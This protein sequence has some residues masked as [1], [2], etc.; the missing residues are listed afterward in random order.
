[1]RK[2]LGVLLFSVIVLLSLSGCSQ[3]D[4]DYEFN[5]G[6]SFTAIQGTFSNKDAIS[7]KGYMYYFST[8]PVFSDY[9][10]STATLHSPAAINGG[11]DV[12]QC[13]FQED[14]WSKTLNFYCGGSATSPAKP[15]EGTYQVNVGST[16]Y[17]FTGVTSRTIDTTLNDIYMPVIKLTMDGSGKIS[18]VEWQWWKKTA[19]SWSQPSN[20]ELMSA[21]EDAGFETSAAGWVGD[22]VHGDIATTSTGSVTPAAQS[23]T[24]GVFRVFYTDSAGYHYG[25]E[26]Q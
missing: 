7:Y 12:T 21:I 6:Q 14:G 11:N 20:S 15:P 1:M 8:C 24:P 17:N 5:G 16:S 25:F 22:R 18:H 10:W 2:S 4:V 26:W 9:P 23:F 3:L 13:W 19:G